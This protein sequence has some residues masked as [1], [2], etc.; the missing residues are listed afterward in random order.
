M[1]EQKQ[2]IGALHNRST[3]SIHTRQAASLC[4]GKSIEVNNKRFKIPSLFV[5]G[6]TLSKLW[7]AVKADDPYAEQH[8][9]EIERLITRGFEHIEKQEKRLAGFLLKKP[10]PQGMTMTLHESRQTLEIS[11]DNEVFQAT[12]TKMMSVLV[13]SFDALVRTLITYKDFAIIDGKT[14][15]GMLKRST[16][17]MRSILMS[18]TTYKKSEVTRG[19]ILNKTDKGKHAVERFGL[20]PM[21]LLRREQCSQYGPQP[22]FIPQT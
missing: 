1:S 14:Y 12:H 2:H 10:T 21:A 3:L 7:Q 4:E 6:L 22:L 17:V 19:D 5:F 13:A 11:L 8:L 20:I 15:Q 16:R 9:I 18:S